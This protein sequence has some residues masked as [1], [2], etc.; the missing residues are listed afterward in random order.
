MSNADAGGPP[1]GGGG[2][3][4]AN[5]AQTL[6]THMPELLDAVES[7]EENAGYLWNASCAFLAL[8]GIAFIRS[9]HN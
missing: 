5:A 3:P 2:P 9:R 1:G 4:G 7:N 8:A 6:Y